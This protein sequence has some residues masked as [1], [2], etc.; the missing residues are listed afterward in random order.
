MTKILIVEDDQQQQVAYARTL[1][2]AG[3]EIALAADAVSAV[4]SAVAQRPDLI[5][6]DLGLP[7]GDG[8][9]VLE[10]LRNLPV[11]SITPAIAVTGGVMNFDR[12]QRLRDLGCTTIL[13]KP[14]SSE[15]LLASVANVLGAARPPNELAERR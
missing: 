11:T 8:G 9:L 1:G 4:S 12:E 6:L 10:R 2:Q 15:Q 13:V 14:V 7:A 3:Y 5:M